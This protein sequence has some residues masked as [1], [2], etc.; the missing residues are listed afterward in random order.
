[1]V[2]SS[3]YTL[4]LLV[5]L[6]CLQ[7]QNAV[8]SG[9]IVD[10]SDAAIPNVSVTLTNKGTSVRADTVSNGEG[11]FVFP[12]QAPGA[13]ELSATAAGFSVARVD[14]ITLEVGQS[15][16]VSLTLK[17]GEVK[18]SITVQDAAPLL[19]VDRADRG[20]VVEN[21]FVQSIPLNLR[22]PLL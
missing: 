21:K 6:Q 7:A 8:V 17:P 22:N 19:T 2:S 15:R 14:G 20:T 3:R 5:C 12:P 11:Y 16:T 4:L 1:M 9:R 18:E 10:S 13:Y